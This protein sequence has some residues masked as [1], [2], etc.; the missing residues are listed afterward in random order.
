[1]RGGLVELTSGGGGGGQRAD[2]SP[3][4]TVAWELVRET[5]WSEWGWP[6]AVGWVAAQASA[7]H[8][9]VQIDGSALGDAGNEDAKADKDGAGRPQPRP[10]R[11]PRRAE[12]RVSLTGTGRPGPGCARCAS[13]NDAH[14]DE[15]AKGKADVERVAQTTAQR[16]LRVGDH[17]RS[18][19]ADAGWHE[20]QRPLGAVPQHHGQMDAEVSHASA[21]DP[22]D[23]DCR[24][25]V[26]VLADVPQ[27]PSRLLTKPDRQAED[28]RQ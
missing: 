7:S 6:V 24:H 2:A 26:S 8:L 1:M 20:Q 12:E 25:V 4:R 5:W 21:A 23:P 19:D 15:A 18:G 17:A 11:A 10:W 14:Q 13:L 27:R 9:P 28:E 16:R 22:E 3:A